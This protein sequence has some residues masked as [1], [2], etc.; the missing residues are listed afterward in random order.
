MASRTIA[1]RSRLL[2]GYAVVLATVLIGYGFLLI[3]VMYLGTSPKRILDGHYISIQAAERMIQT[4]QAQQNEFLRGLLEP[5]PARTQRSERAERRFQDWLERAARH[6]TLAGEPA[7]LAAIRRHYEHLRTRIAERQRRAGAN[8]PA[9]ALVDAFDRVVALCRRLAALHHSAMIDIG[10][11]ARERV[12]RVV[13]SAGVAAFGILLLGLLIALDGARRLSTPIHQLL[14]GARLIAHGDYGVQVPESS[15]RELAQLAHQFNTMARA[16]Q[17]FRSMDLERVLHEQRRSEAVLQSIDDGLV[18]L[19]H[20]GHVERINPVAARQLGIEPETGRGRQLDALLNDHDIDTAVRHSLGPEPGTAR[21]SLSRELR[22]DHAGG[23]R[24]LAYTVVP[25]LGERRQRLGAV[26]VIRDISEHKA[27]ERMRNEFVVHASHELRTPLT[28]IRMGIGMLA[29]RV[30]WAADSREQELLKTATEELDRL[31][32]LINDLFDLSRLQ[33][34]HMPL[35]RE[36]C[37]L[38]ALLEASRQRFEF[39]ADARA[40][41]LCL[42]PVEPLPR[43]RLDSA[44]FARVLDNLLGNALRHTP[45]GGRIRLGAR[46]RGAG[47]I[48]EI[49]DTGSG[50]EPAQQHR[51]FEP[52]MQA[53]ERD[54]GAGL[55]L[56]ICREIIHQHGGR[57]DLHSVPGQGTTFSLE[58]PA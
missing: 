39:E 43:L 53:P 5:G 10:E 35:E 42:A 36:V 19:G 32:R 44:R 20:D 34:G 55:G 21:E 8:P 58:L 16:L 22:I 41:T 47:V 54:D 6:A 48:L 2:S 25:V 26:M 13:Y 38:A 3:G 46:R 52:F 29:E 56:A 1:L 28:G 33:A 31:D 7:L 14:T 4:V 17:D 51:V 57:I 9:D 30:P 50:I 45:A 40:V 37:D 15:T 23:T 12:Q 27:F 18:I 49:A 11:Q 24:H